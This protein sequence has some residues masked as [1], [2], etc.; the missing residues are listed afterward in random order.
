MSEARATGDPEPVEPGS[1]IGLVG[2]GRWGRNILRDLVSLGCDVKVV[3]RSKQSRERALQGGSSQIVETVEELGAVDGI[4]IS[5]PAS[6]H[7]EVA[8]LALRHEVPVFVEKPMTVD[9]E[10]AEGLARSAG[11][12]IFVMDKWR[13]HPGVEALA[14]IV[15]SG[16]LGAVTGLRTTR[17]GWGHI[18]T[19]I[20]TIW[21]HTPHDLA[22]WLEVMGSVPSPRFAVAETMNGEVTGLIGVLGSAPWLKV[23]NSAGAHERR[24]EV[25]L[26]CEGGTAWLSDG[27][28]DHIKVATNEV[29]GGEPELRPISTEMP[30]L[31][32]LKAFLGHV[33]GGPPPRST[34]TEAAAV[35]A[36]IAQLRALA[37]ISD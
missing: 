2:C 34:A 16:E 10:S 25:R 6:T 22:I 15:D 1:S 30:L 4:I 14:D 36:C 37:G 20:D 13:Y 5:T 21:R 23:D 19:D 11:D 8:Q 17:T 35:V 18:Y 9:A 26:I 27:Y 7:Y 24:R 12:R 3:A 32:E 28:D 31:R 29:I 33:Q